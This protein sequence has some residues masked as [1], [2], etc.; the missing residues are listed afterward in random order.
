MDTDAKDAIREANRRRGN[1]PKCG[2]AHVRELTAE[3]KARRD[4]TFP[5]LRYRQ[6]PA[7]GHTWRAKGA[8]TS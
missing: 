5:D 2:N 1:C 4:D 8:P 7:C 3:E 6:C